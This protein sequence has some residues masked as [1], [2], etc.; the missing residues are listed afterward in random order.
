MA[1][2]QYPIRM[3]ILFNP[4]LFVVLTSPWLTLMHSPGR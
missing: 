1:I 4:N 2:V 3:P